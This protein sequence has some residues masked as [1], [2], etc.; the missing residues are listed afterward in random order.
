MLP[1]T[2]QQRLLLREPVAVSL[3]AWPGGGETAAGPAPL[4]RCWIFARGAGRGPLGPAAKQQGRT[5]SPPNTR[6]PRSRDQISGFVHERKKQVKMAGY[7]PLSPHLLIHKPQ[8]S[9]VLPV[10]HRVT[11]IVLSL[12]LLFVLFP[13]KFLVYSINILGIYLIRWYLNTYLAW[14]IASILV[15]LVF[16]FFY[17]LSNGVRHLI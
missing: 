12:G 4:E 5:R 11:G 17:H 6:T 7:R 16:S 1:R 8:S 10:F 13:L 14:V 15:I 3:P 2:Q 9:S